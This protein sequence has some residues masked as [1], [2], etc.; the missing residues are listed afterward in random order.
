MRFFTTSVHCIYTTILSSQNSSLKP[1]QVTFSGF[2]KC[3]ALLPYALL[4]DINLL[5]IDFTRF[6]YLEISFL[7]SSFS[8]SSLASSHPLFFIS[9]LV[10]KVCNDDFHCLDTIFPNTQWFYTSPNVIFTIYMSCLVRY[11]LS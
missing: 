1:I 5:P 6:L 10:C 4:I 3:L 7:V 11:S 8:W 2:L 9:V